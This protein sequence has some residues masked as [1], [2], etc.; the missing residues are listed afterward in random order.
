MP[1]LR[2]FLALWLGLTPAFAGTMSLL[3]AGA[4]AAGGGG[5]CSATPALD[6]TPASGSNGGATTNVTIGQTTHS[7]DLIFV[8]AN[9]NGGPFTTISD[10]GAGALSAWTAI[11][12][13]GA[14]GNPIKTW[15]AVA[16]SPIA[17]SS[18]TI[19]V[20][21]TSASGVIMFVWAVSGANTSSPLDG[22]A[23]TGHPDP[24]SISTT[25]ATD[26]IFATYRESSVGSPTVGSG[27]TL[28][29][30]P[31]AGFSLTEFVVVTSTQSG[32]SLT[33]TTGAGNANGGI[34]V[35]IKCA[36]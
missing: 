35:A 22:S 10:N 15:F 24:L 20:N 12:T 17:A 7:N 14:V 31:A 28:I 36:P 2:I 27:F 6:G 26:F 11:A 30:A 33:Q 1:F 23:V 19:T 21:Q 3:G 5:S 29:S 8:S 13:D 18:I 32:L 34:G 9:G 16:A 25:N 4:P